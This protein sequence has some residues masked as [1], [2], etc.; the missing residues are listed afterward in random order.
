M[1]RRPPRST[2][3]PYTTL[4]RSV[5]PVPACP[6]SVHLAHHHVNTAHDGHHVRDEMVAAHEVD[7]LQVDEAGGT[8]LAP[9]RHVGAVTDQV[10]AHFTPGA[11]HPG[12][13]FAVQ[14]EPAGDVA[15]E[16]SLGEV[17]Q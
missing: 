11:L 2:L 15:H 12:V 13:R 9:V 5:P 1:I 3:F 6:S 7:R 8:P 16:G 14:L 10:A 4:F 17:P